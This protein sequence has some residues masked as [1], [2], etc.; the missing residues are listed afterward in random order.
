MEGQGQVDEEPVVRRTE[1][2]ELKGREGR[3]RGET[4]GAGT[5]DEPGAEELEA[6]GAPALEPMPGRGQLV[7]VPGRPGGQRRRLVVEAHRTAVP[8]V[9]QG[10]LGLG[11]TRLEV[12]LEEQQSQHPVAA[13]SGAPPRQEGGEHEALDEQVVPLERQEVASR[14]RVA[15]VE[16]RREREAEPGPD[17]ERGQERQHGADR[18]PRVQHGIAR[19]E[20][21]E[22]REVG[23]HPPV[24]GL[25][26]LDQGGEGQQPVAPDQHVDLDAQGDP[27]VQGTQPEQGVEEPGDPRPRAAPEPTGDGTGVR[28]GGG[29][30]APRVVSRSRAHARGRRGGRRR[31]T[32]RRPGRSSGR[33]RRRARRPRPCWRAGPA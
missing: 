8:P 10:R 5:Q 22:A 30:R 18:D 4:G 6:E 20:Q 28:A 17:A 11:Q 26:A 23:P 25:E 15:Q 19:I 32:F 9:A 2:Q 13:G 31:R 7:G 33:R 3:E 27:G 16:G 24:Q 29:A 14:H 21:Q 12:E 1:V